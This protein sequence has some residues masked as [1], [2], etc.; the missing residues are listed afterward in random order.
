MK[1]SKYDSIRSYKFST[2]H[3]NFIDIIRSIHDVYSVD[4]PNLTAG[5]QKAHLNEYINGFRMHVVVP[6]HTVEDIYI[7][8]NIKEK[9]HWVLA[10]LSFSESVFY[11]KK[12][13]DLQNHPRYKDKDSSGMFDVLFEEN[14]PQQSSESL[15]CGLYMITY[16]EYHSYDHKVL[17]IEFDPNALRTRYVALLLDYGIRK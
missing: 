17:S 2:V 14:L 15:D 9:H 6:W 8:D 1:K 16:A 3:C 12:G 7:P 4:D 11:D 13:I 5:G 10:V